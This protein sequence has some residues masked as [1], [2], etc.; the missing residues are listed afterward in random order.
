MDGSLLVIL[1]LSGTVMALIFAFT[2]GFQ[3]ASATAATMVA[4]GAASPRSAIAL[5]AA[6]NFLGA[7]LGGSAVALTISGLVTVPAGEP[8]VLVLLSALI[9]AISWNVT[10]WYLGLPSSSTHA[11][12]GGLIGAAIAAGGMGSVDWGVAELLGP[13]HSLQGVVLV[14]LFL[15]VSVIFGLVGGY[16]LLRFSYV[17]LRNASRRAN[18]PIKKVQWI[19]ASLLSFGNGA[20]DSQKQMGIII[21]IVLS[22]GLTT[23]LEVPTWVRISTALALG[24]GTLGG[25]WR[26]MRTL[27]RRIF[28]IKPIHSLDSQ[29]VAGTSVLVST[30]AGAPVSSTQVVASSIIGVGA[31][32][33]IR[34]VRWSVGRDI[35]LSWTVTVP[36]TGLLSG[37]IYSV[38]ILLV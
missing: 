27:G 38:V 12:V 30:L 20:N 15:F 14:F 9:G 16:L 36:I 13:Q 23:S 35:L 2:N 26:I 1:A 29:I 6:M 19:G 11:I 32:E 7:I 25:G 24:L 3:D 31:A 34:K 37:I 17:L 18:E 8:L 10:T 4:C 22:A 28:S 33:N 5:V 21:L